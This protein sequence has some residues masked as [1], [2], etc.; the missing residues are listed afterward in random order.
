MENIALAVF[1]MIILTMWLLAKLLVIFL[2]VKYNLNISF[3]LTWLFQLKCIEIVKS[4]CSSPPNTDG[5]KREAAIEK[6]MHIKID[7]IWLSSCYLNPHV[8]ERLAVCLNAVKISY[9][10]QRVQSTA[11][12]S[13]SETLLSFENF[14]KSRRISRILSL[15]RRFIALFVNFFG[16]ILVNQVN[17][18]VN[19]TFICFNIKKVKG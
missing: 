1:L 11:V 2:N 4:T 7:K 18:T 17:F 10:G 16:S 14:K 9:S 6:K 8:D 15:M 19:D 13:L 5:V 12:T 3:R